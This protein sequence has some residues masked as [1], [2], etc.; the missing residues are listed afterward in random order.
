MQCRR[1][2]TPR[3]PAHCCLLGGGG[4]RGGAG[5]AVGLAALGLA[6]LAW[7]LRPLV[8]DQEVPS[9]PLP[10]THGCQYRWDRWH[11]TLFGKLALDLGVLSMMMLIMMVINAHH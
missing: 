7:L 9:H 5:L 11:A 2:E 8:L 10:D 1:T 6:L 3:L 4:C